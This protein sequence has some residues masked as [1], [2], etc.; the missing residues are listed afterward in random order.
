MG[1][2]LVTF[3]PV[4]SK[5]LI[6][7]EVGFGCVLSAIHDFGWNRLKGQGAIYRFYSCEVQGETWIFWVC[8]KPTVLSDL[9]SNSRV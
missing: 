7:Q 4:A 5:L 6:S 2:N 1:G 3:I 8:N 9:A